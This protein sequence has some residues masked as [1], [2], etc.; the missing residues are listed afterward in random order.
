[1]SEVNQIGHPGRPKD[2]KWH[3][4]DLLGFGRSFLGL[5]GGRGLLG[6]LITTENHV[7]R[8]WKAGYEGIKCDP[9][10][11]LSDENRA[12]LFL[13]YSYLL[14]LRFWPSFGQ[15]CAGVGGLIWIWL[16]VCH[17]EQSILRTSCFIFF[18]F[19]DDIL[20]GIYISS[21]HYVIAMY[22]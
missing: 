4:C 6:H 3:L 11:P 2:R 8:H 16:G 10:L 17:K 22:V 13:Y 5:T 19:L 20:S 7:G 9:A 21:K 1:M 15:L 12:S 14:K 18:V